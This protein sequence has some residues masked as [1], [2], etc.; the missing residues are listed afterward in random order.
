MRKLL[1]VGFSL[2]LLTG[3][4]G[5][6]FV[7]PARA[8][9]FIVNNTTDAA[10]FAPGDGVCETAAGNGIC[11][12]RAAIREANAL[13]GDDTITQTERK[14]QFGQAGYEGSD[15]QCS[16]QPEMN[17]RFISVLAD[18]PPRPWRP[19]PAGSLHLIFAECW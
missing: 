6:V 4:L 13:A 10:D 17:R 19:P 11:T 1:A 16:I 8:A 5:A 7:R 9:S 18:W 14:K 15:A 12:L 3:M 2:T